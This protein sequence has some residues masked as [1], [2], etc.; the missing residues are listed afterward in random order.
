MSRSFTLSSQT[1]LRVLR[2]DCFVGSAFDLASGAVGP[3]QLNK[4]TAI[5]DT[6]ATG[7]VI[8]Q[9]V[10]DDL[11]LKP[12]GMTIAQGVQGQHNTEVYLV[13][14]GLPNGVGFKNIRVT[15]GILGSV[16]VLIGMDIIVEGDF[17][18]THKD[19]K[20]CFSFRC[21]SSDRIDFVKPDPKHVPQ[22]QGRNDRCACGSG[23]KYK[24]CCGKVA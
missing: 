4:Y 14:L 20:T 5:W 6:G 15:K 19:G 3:Q 13:S 18:I 21:P 7:S 9:K 10:V 22:K 12:I 16:D 1:R 23:K 2:T 8:T 11:A 24:H 17:A